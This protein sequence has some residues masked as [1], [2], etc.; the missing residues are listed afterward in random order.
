MFNAFEFFVMQHLVLVF[1]ALGM[2]IQRY[3]NVCWVL[4][5]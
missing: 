5:D 4:T 2:E 1:Q 3:R